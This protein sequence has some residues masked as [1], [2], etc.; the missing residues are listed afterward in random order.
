MTRPK[1]SITAVANSP[2]TASPE[3]FSGE[4]A[5][6]KCVYAT[7]YINGAASVRTLRQRRPS[8]GAGYEKRLTETAA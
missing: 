8:L 6:G 2:R 5:V 1:K 4:L 7:F 3:L